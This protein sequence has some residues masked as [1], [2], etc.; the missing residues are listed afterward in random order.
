MHMILGRCDHDIA[1]FSSKS[2]DISI[3][4]MICRFA[5]LVALHFTSF[6]LRQRYL[7]DIS[8]CY[9]EALVSTRF[10]LMVLL[11]FGQLI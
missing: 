5:S 11:H 8:V 6:R 10:C 9:Y 2:S 1:H 4:L 7:N 3:T